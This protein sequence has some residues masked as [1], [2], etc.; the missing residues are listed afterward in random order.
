MARIQAG[1]DDVGIFHCWP[2]SLGKALPAGAVI[3]GVI[4]VAAEPSKQGIQLPAPYVGKTTADSRILTPVP[5]L[6]W[7]LR[8]WGDNRCPFLIQVDP[9]TPGTPIPIWTG[10]ARR[11]PDALSHLSDGLIAR[12]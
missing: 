10:G 7:D 8:P 9:A 3:M 4:I 6:E 2:S 11:S 5:N 12:P 1:A